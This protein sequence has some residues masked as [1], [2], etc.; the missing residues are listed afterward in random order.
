MSDTIRRMHGSFYRYIE[1]IDEANR[2]YSEPD[3]YIH[4][5]HR[6]THRDA[7]ARLSL[8]VIFAHT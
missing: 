4:T 5:F 3:R 8:S 7:Y 1:K 2:S 6:K